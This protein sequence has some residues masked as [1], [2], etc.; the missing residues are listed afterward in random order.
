MCLIIMQNGRKTDTFYFHEY[1][2]CGILDTNAYE[3][4]WN[5]SQGDEKC[6]HPFD[7]IRGRALFPL[8]CKWSY[9][10]TSY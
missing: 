8:I 4:S 9:F 7:G 1:Q 10:L 3:L 6:E 2:A 5:G